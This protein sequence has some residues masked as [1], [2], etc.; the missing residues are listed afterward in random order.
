MWPALIAIAMSAL[1]QA[2]QQ[3]QQKAQA[4]AANRQQNYQTEMLWRQQQQQEKSQRDLLKQQMSKNRASLAA[5]GMS[6]DNGSGAALLAG[7]QNQASQG[8]ADGY[9][10]AALQHMMRNSESS[11]SSGAD[12]LLRGLSMAKDA[13]SVMSPLFSK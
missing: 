4:E 11:Q 8:I 5:G 6:A 10:D 2:Q 7:M 3:Q 1:Q 13:Y 12:G 9:G